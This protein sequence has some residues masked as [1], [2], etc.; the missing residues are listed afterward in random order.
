MEHIVAI[1]GRPNVGKSALFN[2]LAGRDISLVFDRPGTTRDRLVTTARWNSHK[3]TLI[4]TGGIGVEDREGFGDEI[5][6][7][8][9]LALAAATEIIFVVDAREGLTPLDQ[10]VTRLLRKSHCP[11][12][13]AANKVDG[14]KQVNLDAEFTRL[15]F[16]AVFPVSAAHR[17]GLDD[18]RE[19]ITANWDEPEK[20]ADDAVKPA[21]ATRLAIVGRPNVGKSSLINALVSEPRAIVSEVAGTTRDAVDIAYTWKGAPYLFIDT[22]G[23]RQERR[24]HD[25][26]ERAMTGRTAHAINRADVCILVIDASTGVTMQDKKIAG[27]IQDAHAPCMI[28]VNKWDLARE[29][30]DAS[31]SKEREYYEQVKRDMFFLSYAPILFLSAKSGE[32]IEGLL[33]TCAIIAKNRTFRFQTGPLNRVISRAMEKYAPPLVHGRRFKVL[34]A[35]QQAAKEG[36][37]EIPTLQLFVNSADL[38]TPAYERYLDLQVREAFDLKGCPLRFNLRGRTTGAREKTRSQVKTTPPP[39]RRAPK[40]VSK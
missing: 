36:T 2:A 26:L 11:V 32:R 7:E 31:R 3:L 34:Y 25:Q 23:M 35:A 28:V 19:T 13:V 6:R 17:R 15:G 33:K 20:E 21:R 1:V 10:I 38:L 4:D 22:A 24:M 27:L 12:Y 8:V 5:A 37:R 39:P 14:D 9:E 40:R 18:L 30:G 29:Q 16:K